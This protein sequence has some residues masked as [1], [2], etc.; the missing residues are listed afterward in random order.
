MRQ[1]LLGLK[2]SSSILEQ[3]VFSLRKQDDGAVQVLHQPCCT[4]AEQ[5]AVPVGLIQYECRGVR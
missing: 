5:A 2:R 3:T 4:D 1:L